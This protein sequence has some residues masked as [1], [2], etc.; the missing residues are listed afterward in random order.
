[1]PDAEPQ[2]RPGATPAAAAPLVQRMRLVVLGLFMLGLLV[3]FYLA[4]RGAFGASSYSTH[5]DFGDAL[6]LVT[7]VIL[8]LTLAS[9]AT[10]NRV[11]IVH[12]ILLIVLFEVQLAL[13]DLQHP[14]AGA[15]HP[16]NALLILGVAYSFFRRD[17]RA[18]R[19]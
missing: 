9:G 2:A 5:K 10:R 6:H 1:M 17:F 4:G 18:V 14:A 16:V 12:S 15:F 3:Q 8:V 19:R 13:A 11:D 7:P